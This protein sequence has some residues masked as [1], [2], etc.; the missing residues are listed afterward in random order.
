MN[1]DSWETASAAYNDVYTAVKNYSDCVCECVTI[2]W[3]R[4]S[5]PATV[6][7]SPLSRLLSLSLPPTESPAL[8]SSL[9]EHTWGTGAPAASAARTTSSLTSICCPEEAF[10]EP[11]ESRI[12]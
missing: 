12:Q 3:I 1:I 2:D 6:T 5:K 11:G 7:P 9:A 8:S 4:L 10:S